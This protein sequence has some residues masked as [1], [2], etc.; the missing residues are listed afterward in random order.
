MCIAI[1]EK[2]QGTFNKKNNWAYL[3]TLNVEIVKECTQLIELPWPCMLGTDISTGV[4]VMSV[5]TSDS[6]EFLSISKQS[7]LDH[8]LGQ[9]GLTRDIDGY[10]GDFIHQH[11]LRL[12]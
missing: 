9:P 7:I 1:L 2:V 3:S 10:V 4:Y 11:T 6:I 8:W 5:E 12:L